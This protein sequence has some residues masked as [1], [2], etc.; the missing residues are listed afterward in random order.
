MESGLQT[1][2]PIIVAAFRNLLQH[3]AIVVLLLLA[4]LA[5][6]WHVLRGAQLRKV[7]NGEGNVEVP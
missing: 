2:N 6:G 3:Q 4:V 5:V 1:N 7:A